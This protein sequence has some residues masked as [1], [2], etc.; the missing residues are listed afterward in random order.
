MRGL[1]SGYRAWIA[2]HPSFLEIR[3]GLRLFVQFELGKRG[4]EGRD[5]ISIFVV[6]LLFGCFASP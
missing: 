4:D 5:L 6:A 3:R 2:S 1:L